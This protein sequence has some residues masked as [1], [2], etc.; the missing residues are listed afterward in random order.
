MRLIDA[1][2][3]IDHKFKSASERMDLSVAYMKGWNDAIDSI[4]ENA[5]TIDAV[6][7]V[8]C[9]DCKYYDDKYEYCENNDIFVKPNGYC[10]YGEKKE[11]SAEPVRHG[12]WEDCSN[13]WMCSVC[14][15][16]VSKNYNYCPNCGAKMDLDEVE[17]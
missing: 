14:H 6:P 13:G 12:K 5:P 16:D 17:K 11:Q 7:V 2:E 10:F 4:D 8:R 15:R 3:L 1:D 9:K